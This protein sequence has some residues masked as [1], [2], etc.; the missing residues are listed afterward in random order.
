MTVKELIKFLKKYPKDMKV[1]YKIFSEQCILEED[2]IE[3][4]ELCSPRP[5][6]WIQN[7]RVDMPTEEYL[8]LPG[9]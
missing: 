3:V 1:A 7:H 6:G 8:V 5:D 2:N 9:N 4:R